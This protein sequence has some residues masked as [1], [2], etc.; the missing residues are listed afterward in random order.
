MLASRKQSKISAGSPVF[1]VA[2]ACWIRRSGRYLRPIG[3]EDSSSWRHRLCSVLSTCC[4]AAQNI[5]IRLQSF[6]LIDLLRD[7]C[8]RRSKYYPSPTPA[9]PQ[10]LRPASERTAMGKV[11]C[12]S[13]AFRGLGSRGG[14]SL[15]SRPESLVLMTRLPSHKQ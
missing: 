2:R 6:E 4:Y 12:I 9:L 13:L 14:C 11:H 5:P 10:C 7:C 3:I 1:G 15:R 8:V